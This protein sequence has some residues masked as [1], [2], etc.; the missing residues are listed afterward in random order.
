MIIIAEVYK[1]AAAFAS[2]VA[3]RY[4]KK[5]GIALPGVEEHR[6]LLTDAGY[7]DVQ[8][9]T[10]PGKGWICRIGRRTLFRK[11][12]SKLKRV[13]CMA[14]SIPESLVAPLDSRLKD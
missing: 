10:E 6:E 11:A 14:R 8:I 3:E 2:K 5:T 4:F 9:I 13:N 12:R 1:G 7:S